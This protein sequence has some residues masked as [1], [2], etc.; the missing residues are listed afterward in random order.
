VSSYKSS[1]AGATI[2]TN[3]LP[4]LVSGLSKLFLGLEPLDPKTDPY[5]VPVFMVACAL[6]GVL[7]VVFD[8][9]LRHNRGKSITGSASGLADRPWMLIS[10]PLGAA[11]FGFIGLVVHVLQPSFLGGLVA[12]TSWRI[13]SDDVLAR[14][15]IGTRPRGEPQD[16]PPKA[17]EED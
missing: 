2:D 10:W 14:L 12:A 6:L 3:F 16:D 15:H 13:A 4:A 17:G 1:G 9:T 5:Y 8:W 7:V 11:F